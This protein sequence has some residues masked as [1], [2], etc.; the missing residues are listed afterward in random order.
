MNDPYLKRN[1]FCSSVSF[2]N[3]DRLFTHIEDYTSIHYF[4]V[5]RTEKVMTFKIINHDEKKKK[6]L[7]KEI[8]ECIDKL[9]PYLLFRCCAF[10]FLLL[11]RSKCMSNL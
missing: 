9:D 11:G 3:P 4:S 6:M 7:F 1:Q 2:V 8:Q 5:S 10:I